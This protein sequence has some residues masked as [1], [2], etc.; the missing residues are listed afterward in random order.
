MSR[1][2]K[3][4]KNERAGILFSVGTHI[5]VIVLFIF[6]IAWRAPNPPLPEFGIELNFGTSDAGTGEIQPETTPAE[7]ESEEEAMPDTPEEVVEETVEETIEETTEETEAVEEE[8]V[9]VTEQATEAPVKEPEKKPVEV[10]PKVEEKKEDPK[11]PKVLYPGTKEG[12]AGTT[13]D[14]KDAANANEGDDTD[15]LGNKGKKDGI[16]DRSIYDGKPG[17]GDGGGSA[18]NI[19]GWNW[20]REPRP[21]HD[22][23]KFDG[24]ITFDFQV[25]DKGQVISIT[26]IPPSTVSSSLIRLYKDELEKT[27]FNPIGS[28]TPP[29]RTKGRVT[30]II[31][32]K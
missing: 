26:T 32:A 29:P 5:A 13:G 8:I 10:T 3:D 4:K 2:E 14:A 24:K 11:P 25:D 20:D 27:T 31:K 7:A 6:L 16:D 28:G 9:P 1:E 30:F 18:L 19:K 17:G 12:A 21:E 22:K 23:V 15:A